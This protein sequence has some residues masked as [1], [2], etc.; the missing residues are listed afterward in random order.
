MQYLN[1]VQVYKCRI[2]S[3][4]VTWH[5]SNLSSA[6]LWFTG[7]LWNSSVKRKHSPTFSGET[8]SSTTLVHDCKTVMHIIDILWSPYNIDFMFVL[9]LILVGLRMIQNLVVPKNSEF[10]NEENKSENAICSIWLIF[11]LRVIK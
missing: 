10:S 1:I 7:S 4:K 2:K 9:N 6:D 8:K 5:T 3:T 11:F